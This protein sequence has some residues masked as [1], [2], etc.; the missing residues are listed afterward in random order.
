MKRLTLP[1]CGHLAHS[2]TD[3]E[4]ESSLFELSCNAEVRGGEQED[5][6]VSQASAIDQRI[7]C[8]GQKHLIEFKPRRLGKSRST[9]DRNRLE[10]LF[11]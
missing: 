5:L 6:A 7:S 8:R 4:D 3:T 1:S 11:D 10:T 2:D 9:R